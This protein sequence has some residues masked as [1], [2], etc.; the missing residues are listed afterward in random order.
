MIIIILIVIIAILVVLLTLINIVKNYSYLCYNYAIMNQNKK[1]NINDYAEYIKNTFP[2]F[3]NF[4]EN[5]TVTKTQ[6]NNCGKKC[7]NKKLNSTAANLSFNN[8][9]SDS[10]KQHIILRGPRL[11]LQ[12]VRG[13]IDHKYAIPV[14]TGGSSGNTFNYWYNY[15]EGVKFI[16]STMRCWTPYGWNPEKKIGVFYG[17]PSSG[18][19]FLNN[20]HLIIP[21]IDIVIPTF[22]KNGDINN[23][24]EFIKFINVRKPYVI[25]TMPNLLFRV[26]QHLYISGI[27]LT[28]QPVMI[29]LSGDFLFTCQY[30]FIKLFFPKS[31]IRMAY[32]TVEF[33]QI[34][35]QID[36]NNLYTYKVFNEYAYVENTK[37]GR[38]IVS[39]YDYENMPMYRYVTDDYGDVI[40]DKNDQQYIINLVGKKKYDYIS[41]DEII[42]KFSDKYKII[43]VR[44]DNKNKLE[45]TTLLDNINEL[46]IS[47]RK[48][49]PNYQVVI[50]KCLKNNCPTKDRFDTKVLPLVKSEFQ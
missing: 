47:T 23:I 32:G 17:H 27:K 12:Y 2:E 16:G 9:N 1:R 45:L 41:L 29:S 18:L 7:I 15:D 26:C 38:L 37:D 44:F 40:T 46:S 5:N 42:N 22:K 49:F 24:S 48:I 19:T 8:W 4:T 39:R 33:G 36:D 14:C 13:Y 31:I 30:K 50:I 43:N 35:Q 3:Y 21:K 20:I 34:A 6:L 10:Q 25:E 28:Y 11:F